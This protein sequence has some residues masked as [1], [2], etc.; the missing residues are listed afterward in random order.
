RCPPLGLCNATAGVSQENNRPS[1]FPHSAGFA[2][3]SP[4]G[5]GEPHDIAPR[6]SWHLS[7]VS[8]CTYARGP[9]A[10]A[11]ALETLRPNWR[12]TPGSGSFSRSA[13]RRAMPERR[14]SRGTLAPIG[15]E[16]LGGHSDDD[17]TLDLDLPQ[18][19]P[20]PCAD[21]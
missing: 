11:R 10:L 15:V 13:W 1:G 6:G 2:I 9:Q 19:W 7:C 3:C 16:R 5:I 18:V 20:W 12:A 4:R 21:V 14:I 17:A 8:I